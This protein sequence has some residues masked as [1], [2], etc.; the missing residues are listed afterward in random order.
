LVGSDNGSKIVEKLEQSASGDAESRLLAE[1][2]DELGWGGGWLKRFR[3]TVLGKSSPDDEQEDEEG[4]EN[5]DGQG[6]PANGEEPPAQEP[7]E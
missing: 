1:R 2:V 4:E 6:G 3:D 7:S 5:D